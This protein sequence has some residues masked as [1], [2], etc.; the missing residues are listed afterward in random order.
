MKKQLLMLVASAIATF[1]FNPLFARGSEPVQGDGELLVGKMQQHTSPVE[2]SFGSSSSFCETMPMLGFDTDNDDVSLADYNMLIKGRRG[3]FGS[4]RFACALLL[5]YNFNKIGAGVRFA[6]NFTDLLRFC[7]DG[8]YYFYD[9]PSRR[10]NT[11]SST[12]EKG[13]DGWGRRFDINPTLNFVFGDGDFHF[14]LIGGLYFSYGYQQLV[15][16]VKEFSYAFDGDATGRYINGEWYYYTDELVPSIGIGVV[17]GCGI[18]YQINDSFRLSFEQ[19][20]SVGL[21]TSWMSKLG[22][23]YCF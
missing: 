20:L 2:P 17:G 13:T 16:A 3:R 23:A 18:E 9:V 7:F 21:M 5:D 8:S 1:T 4:N 11:L 10:F 22:F 14:Y 15:N 6:Y 12:G 19:E